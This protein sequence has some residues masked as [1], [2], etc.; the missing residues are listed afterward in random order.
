MISIKY[1]HLQVIGTIIGNFHQNPLK[2]VGGDAETIVS[3]DGLTDRLT[4]GRT[5]N[6]S[7][8][9]LTSGDK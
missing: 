6:Y 5:H 3:M 2:T 8:L 7:P 9:R 4:D 1:A